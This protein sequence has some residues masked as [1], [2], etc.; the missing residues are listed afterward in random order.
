MPAL[1]KELGFQY[2]NHKSAWM[3]KVLFRDWF[4]SSFV[5]AVE[6]YL[7]TKNLS[8]KAVLLLYNVPVHP[9]ENKLISG[10]IR[11][12]YLPPNCT[13]SVQ[14]IDQIRGY[15]HMTI[16][17]S[18]KSLFDKTYS[19]DDQENNT[20]FENHQAELE[21]QNLAELHQ[22]VNQ[23]PVDEFVREDEVGQWLIT[24]PIPDFTD[25]QI[26]EILSE[27]TPE[28]DAEEVE[29]FENDENVDPV[30]LNVLHSAN[31]LLEFAEQEDH[32]DKQT[33][34]GI[35]MLRERVVFKIVQ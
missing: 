27:T 11:V 19:A 8:R 4:F 9:P 10:G 18:W 5:P 24:D 21:A 7:Q 13:A 35:K 12:V 17:R 20:E 29:H 3:S 23:L 25:S 2:G 33:I 16:A 6:K 30:L 28:Q 31:I 32:P 22:L 14:T 1:G 15:S 34:D 26:I